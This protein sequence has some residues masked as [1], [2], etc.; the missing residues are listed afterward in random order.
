MKTSVAEGGSVRVL[1]PMTRVP[2]NPSD[3]GIPSIVIADA[4]GR[5]ISDCVGNAERPKDVT[6]VEDIVIPA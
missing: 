2:E 1:V 3:T 4:P 5:T 6:I